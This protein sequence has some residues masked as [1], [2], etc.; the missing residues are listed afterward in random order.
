MISDSVPLTRLSHKPHAAKARSMS[1]R[2][3]MAV[4]VGE[5]EYK[6]TRRTIKLLQHTVNGT[7]A[8]TARHGD[9][10]LVDVS[11]NRRN[12][13]WSS[14]GHGEMRCGYCGFVWC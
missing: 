10:E 9:V 6:R 11:L 1:R 12:H 8:S 3:A 7:G 13:G 5:G 4:A 2:K 14:F